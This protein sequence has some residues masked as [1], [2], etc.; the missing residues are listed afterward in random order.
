MLYVY[1]F[2]IMLWVGMS[3]ITGNTGNRVFRVLQVVII[4]LN[5]IFIAVNENTS[6]LVEPIRRA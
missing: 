6:F 5:L 2:V 4:F 3:E 1:S